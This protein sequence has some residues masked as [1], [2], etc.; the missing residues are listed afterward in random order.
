MAVQ[1]E[2]A[3]GHRKDITLQSVFVGANFQGDLYLM[4][5]LD[6]VVVAKLLNFVG[7]WVLHLDQLEFGA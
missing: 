6:S 7:M 3:H 4:L 2:V 5:D 1:E